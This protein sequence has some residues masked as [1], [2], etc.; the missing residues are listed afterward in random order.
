MRFADTFADT[1]WW[2]AFVLPSD[3]RHR[4]ALDMRMLVRGSEQILTTNLVVGE[5]W[6]LLQRPAWRRRLKGQRSSKC[7]TSV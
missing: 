4:D 7:R 2:A 3:A 6:T 1:S 5:M